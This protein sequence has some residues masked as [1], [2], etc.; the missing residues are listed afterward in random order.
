MEN[1]GG[2]LMATMTGTGKIIDKDG[3]VKEITLKAKV[4]LEVAKKLAKEQ[5]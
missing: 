3:S 1:K 5:K 4:P 2:E